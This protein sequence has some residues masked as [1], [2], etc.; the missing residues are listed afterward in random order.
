MFPIATLVIIVEI[1]SSGVGVDRLYS[2]V[3][4]I[5]AYIG[6]HRLS[7]EAGSTRGIYLPSENARVPW[8]I[9]FIIM[10]SKQPIL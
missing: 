6:V 3:S 8:N 1:F 5:T 9:A 7:A 2:S 10:Q 4:G